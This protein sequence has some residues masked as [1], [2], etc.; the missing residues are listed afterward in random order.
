[1]WRITI[2][3]RITDPIGLETSLR[4]KFRA[5]CNFKFAFLFNFMTL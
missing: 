2:C 5:A 4:R 3:D 1:M